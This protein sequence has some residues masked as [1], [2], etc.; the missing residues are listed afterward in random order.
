MAGRKKRKVPGVDPEYLDKQKASFTRV[1]R[2]VLYLNDKEMEALNEYCRRF[3][4]RQK[5]V[6]LREAAM[7]HILSELDENHPTLF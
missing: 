4:V 1:H 2:Q 7:E 5:G 3:K 6:L